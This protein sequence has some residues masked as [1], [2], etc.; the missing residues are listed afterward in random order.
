MEDGRR[1]RGGDGV[2]VALV[3]GSE[4]SR[5]CEGHR[6]GVQNIERVRY[7]RAKFRSNVALKE[8]HDAEGLKLPI[9]AGNDPYEKISVLAMVFNDFHS[10]LR[11]HE[12]LFVKLNVDTGIII[13]ADH[14]SEIKSSKS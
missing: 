3:N 8:L 5:G 7:I 1:Q 4:D 13:A 9:Q 6:R 10:L 14:L 2:V 11:N 12:K